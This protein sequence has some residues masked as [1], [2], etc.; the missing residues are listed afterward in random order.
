MKSV[1]LINLL[2][3]FVFASCSMTEEEKNKKVFCMES[4]NKIK[5]LASSKKLL[6]LTSP[7]P[8]ST[9]GKVE[10]WKKVW[11]GSWKK[12]KEEFEVML[13]RNGMG[14]G[15]EWRHWEKYFKYKFKK[16]GDGKTPMG[17]HLLGIKFGFKDKNEYGQ[18]DNYLKIND[19]TI[20][21]DDP[22]SS[23]YNRIVNNAASS[24]KNKDWKSAEQMNKEPLYEQGI[25]IKYKTS[26]AEKAGSCIFMH[27]IDQKDNGTSGCVAMEKKSLDILFKE[28]VDN[29]SIALIIMQEKDFKN[30]MECILE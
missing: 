22:N 16:E 6:V 20:C 23:Y 2:I 7:S 12:D 10:L 26:S 8:E 19:Q 5:E 25:E 27:L 3:F 29:T 11:G 21:V 13:G 30:H 1:I 24:I 14:L 18:L 4:Q 17:I 15:N 9:K 28:A